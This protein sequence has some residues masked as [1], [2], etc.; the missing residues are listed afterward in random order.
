MFI[1][2]AILS[3]TIFAGLSSAAL[4]TEYPLTIT[5]MAG[6]TV[7]VT[8]EP[9]R[10]ALQDGRDAMMLALL[11]REN[12]FRRITV[13][14]NIL[15]RD[16]ASAWKLL[17]GKW[18]AAAKITDM[19]FGDNG[20][21]NLEQLIAGRPQVVFAEA[22][23]MGSLKEAGVES[24]LGDLKIP[25]IYVD[26]F[27]RP[28]PNAAASVD[29]IGKVLNREK[30]ATEYTSFYADHLK[31][32]QEVT[33]RIPVKARVFVE[34]LAGR[35]GPEQCCFTHGKIGWGSLVEAAG[36]ENIGAKL[37]SKAT[38]DVTL[39]TVLAEKPDVYVMTGTQ[40]TRSGAAFAP[41]GYD[42]DPAKITDAMAVLEKRPGFAQLEAA[43][44]GRVF[45]I[46]HLFYNHPYNVVGL[47]HLAKFAYPKE[48]AD[49]DPDA[50]YN[51]IIQRF[52]QIPVQA[53]THAAAAPRVGQ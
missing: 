23:T 13:W 37:L 3:F 15:S 52:T 29:L 10:I 53:F 38:G 34:A 18:P 8:E 14:N 31:H 1:R 36:A 50:T 28:V 12:P 33:V 43:K 7:T 19:G 42:A 40:S 41:F 21:V 16:D 47:E 44:K 49:L 48:L 9:Q 30:E 24:R 35:S 2:R 5:D 27:N 46:W 51:T 32:L 4:A 39:E 6:R 26:S 25:L 22:R 20:Q 45:G 11:D 17:S